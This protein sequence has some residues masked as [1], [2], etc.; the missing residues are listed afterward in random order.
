MDAGGE[1]LSVS[2]L[3]AGWTLRVEDATPAV[4]NEAGSAQVPLPA[5]GVRKA[6][7][8]LRAAAPDGVETW[9]CPFFTGQSGGFGS[10]PDELARRAPFQ[11]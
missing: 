7:L 1:A 5:G 3:P 10:G 2:G 8:R 9:T 4:I 11:A 6:R